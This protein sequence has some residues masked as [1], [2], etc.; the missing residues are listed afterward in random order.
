MFG[1][2]TLKFNIYSNL[3]KLE[4]Q[5]KPMAQVQVDSI[6]WSQKL[7]HRNYKKTLR[8]TTK[9]KGCLT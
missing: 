4:T 5:N 3:Q 6:F 9:S 8:K 7:K 1:L 2:G